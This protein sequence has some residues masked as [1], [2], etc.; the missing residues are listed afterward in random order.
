MLLQNTEGTVRRAFETNGLISLTMSQ[1]STILVLSLEL[2]ATHV[3]ASDL[4]I[5]MIHTQD[6]PEDIRQHKHE[7]KTDDIQN[8][9]DFLDGVADLQDDDN[10][11]LPPKVLLCEPVVPNAVSLDKPALSPKAKIINT[12]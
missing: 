1:R 9:L 10:V 3:G 11:E 8:V 2:L 12:F 4:G 7:T 6:L 5:W